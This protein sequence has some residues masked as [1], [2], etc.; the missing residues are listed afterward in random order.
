MLYLELDRTHERSYSK[1]IYTQIREK[2]LSG[3]LRSKDA[4]PSTR[5]LSKDLCVARNTILT[6]Y[7]MLV[8]DGFLF[9]LPGSGFFVSPGI[10]CE[11]QPAQI[12]DFN[13]ASL[14]DLLVPNNIINFDSGL[15]ALDLFPKSKWNQATTKALNEAPISA[16]GYDDPQGRPEFREVLSTYLKR[17]RGIECKPEQIIITTGTKQG[18]SLIAK[19]LLNAQSEV[20]IENPSNE[21]VNQIF[22]YHTDKIIPFEVDEEGIQPHLFPNQKKPSLI[23]VT[24]S[25][26][27]PMGGILS[28]KRRLELI[29]F[30]RK[31]DCFILEDDYDSEF[32]YEGLPINSLFELDTEHVIY[33]GTFS[34]VMF[35]SLRLGYLVVP[36]LLIPQI[37]KWKR[38][39]DHHS[40]SIYQLALMRFIENGD[41]ERHIRR[42]KREYK[43]RQDNLLALLHTHFGEKF[44]VYGFRAGM[45]VVVEFENVIFTDESIRRLLISGIYV[46]PVEKHSV[47]KGN[48][49]NQII[50]GYA[51]LCYEDMERGLKILKTELSK[52]TED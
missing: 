13:V 29:Q 28:I 2:I 38:L 14:S 21:N 1:Q 24:P 47:L 17:V 42:M 34:K 48:H 51:Q 23:F 43:K 46:V 25:H 11:V 49:S 35:P 36:S 52:E 6:A 5:N 3:A 41:L 32:N 7:D 16:L 45:H 44:K 26:Q 18:L 39:A 8:S 30:A 4:L 40:N 10:T 50:L 20:W 22:A 37:R 9:S 27:F 19:C 33:A 12:S 31:N 15:P